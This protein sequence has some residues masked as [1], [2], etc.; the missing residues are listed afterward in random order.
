MLRPRKMKSVEFTALKK[1]IDA[2]LEYLGKSGSIHFTPSEKPKSSP[3][4]DRARKILEKLRNAAVFAGIELNAGAQENIFRA[5]GE[6]EELT[7]NLLSA[8]E[9]LKNDL[10]LKSREKTRVLEALNEARAYSTLDA[11]F[12]DLERLSFLTLRIGRVDEREIPALRA[13][14]GDRA[15]IIHLAGENRILA[16]SS[17]KGRFALD[18]R[19]KNASFQPVTVSPDCRGI[20]SEFIKNLEE[21]LS[22]LDKEIKETNAKITLFRL[23]NEKALARLYFSWNC[24]LNI[25]EIKAGFNANGSFYQFRGWIPAEKSK[26]VVKELLEITEGRIAVNSYSPSEVSSVI[27]GGEKVPVYV[28]HGAFVKGFQGVVFSYGAPLYGT[29]DPTPIVA[30][31]FTFLFG[32]MFGD[33]GHGFAL[34]FAGLLIKYGPGRLAKFYKYSTPLVSIGISSMFFGL[35][36]GGVFCNEHILTAAT[37]KVTFAVTGNAMDRILTILPLAESGGSLVKLLYFFGFTIAIGIIIISLGLLVNIFNRFTLKKYEEAFFSKSAL[38]GLLMFWYAV[39]IAVRVI[40]GGGFKSLDLVFLLIPLFFI[41][42]GPVIWRLFAGERKIFESGFM[43]FFMEGF[44]EILETVSGYISNTVSFLRVGA[45]ALSH[46]VL[47]YIV[48]RFAGELG[49]PGIP[50]SLASFLIMIFGNAVIIVLEGMIVAIQVIRLQYYEFFN[51]FFVETGVE[52][53]PFR[54]NTER[55]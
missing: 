43:T 44:V 29:I 28:K 23:N 26:R 12:S 7:E 36:Y 49:G 41:F 22:R 37:R 13:S 48:F 16:L 3:E 53:S 34:F 10:E 31:F 30:F 42:F 17:R 46:A 27:N 5:R 19:L 51:K 32:I 6:D 2:A 39:F 21:E 8:S 15:L 20:P 54:I 45:F 14:L 18:S 1:D 11:P 35:L 50:G 33:V 47:S 38:A 52:F 4:A 9:S 55:V 40:A 25:E 24:T